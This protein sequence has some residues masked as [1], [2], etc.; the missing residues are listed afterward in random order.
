M[1]MH[2]INNHTSVR[3][4]CAVLGVLAVYYCVPLDLAESAE[5][6]N[7]LITVL[8]MG[9]LLWIVNIQIRRHLDGGGRFGSL[10]VLLVLVV[11]AFALVYYVLAR[12]QSGQFVGLQTRTDGLYF[13]MTT[14][15]TTGFGDIHAQGGLA[16]ALVTGQMFFDLAFLAMIGST[17]STRIARRDA[18]KTAGKH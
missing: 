9:A 14:L 12:N 10:A 15:T 8:A 5:I 4:S 18:A 2:W 7:L 13:S 1:G 6:V 11:A 16:R 17:V 3:I